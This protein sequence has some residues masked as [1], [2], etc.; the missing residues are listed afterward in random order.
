MRLFAWIMVLVSISACSVTKPSPVTTYYLLDSRPLTVNQKARD[1][2]IEVFS[3]SLPDYLEQP[4]LVIRGKNNQ[5]VIA[6]YHSWADSLSDSIQRVLLRELNKLDSAY[7]FVKACNQCGKLSI[8]IEHFY[9]TESGQVVLSGSF[10]FQT[11]V[12]KTLFQQFVLSDELVADG[13]DNSVSQM[14]QLLVQL[15]EKIVTDLSKSST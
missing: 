2:F 10:Q 5:I 4:N 12:N 3:I 13:Y 6:S 8:S 14:R 1:H 9:P 15:A 7:S 11:G